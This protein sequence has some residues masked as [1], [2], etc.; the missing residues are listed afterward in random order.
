MYRFIVNINGRTES[1]WAES[2]NELM[3]DLEEFYP[4]ADI[5][6]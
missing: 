4:G 5:E 2:E 3:Q 6:F 1:F